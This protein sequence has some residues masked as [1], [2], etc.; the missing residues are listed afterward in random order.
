MT[1]ISIDSKISMNIIISI[2]DIHISI[3]MNSNISTII[4]QILVYIILLIMPDM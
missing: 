3:N 1:Y 4:K 2:N